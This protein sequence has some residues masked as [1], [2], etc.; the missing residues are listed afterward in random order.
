MQSDCEKSLTHI[1]G[2]IKTDPCKFDRFIKSKRCDTIGVPVLHDNNHRLRADV[3]K[4]HCLNNYFSSHFTVE[5]TDTLPSCQMEFPKM[6]KFV[7]TAPGVRKLLANLDG[8]ISAVPGELPPRVLKEM[9]FEVAPP[10]TFIFNQS[11]Q[12]GQVPTDWRHGNIFPLHKKGSK[13]LAT[14][15][16]PIGLFLTS[17]CSK[18]MVQVIYS[19]V[20]KHLKHHGILTPQQYGFWPGFS[21]ETQLVSCIND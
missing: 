20:Y 3:D 16:R 14:N 15:Y 13:S 9:S 6:D 8:S 2:N 21:C 5:N 18:I 17:V 19:S 10:L 4:A 1:I 11:L 12:N 7:I